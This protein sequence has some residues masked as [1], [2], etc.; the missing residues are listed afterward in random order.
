MIKLAHRLGYAGLIPFVG[1]AFQF[2]D[3]TSVSAFMSYAAVILSF[4]GGIHW[5]V[6]MRDHRLAS[7]TVLAVSMLPSLM[8]WFA[9]LLPINLGLVISLL[10]YI[11]WWAW[12]ATHIEDAD[13]RRLR[14]HLTI[15]VSICH[16]WLIAQLN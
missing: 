1:L 7:N 15:V 14:T 11:T 6:A 2:E 5:G 4:L 13:Y 8:A 9:M 16:L 3:E 12:D 10:A